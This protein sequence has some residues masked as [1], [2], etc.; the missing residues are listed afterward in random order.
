MAFRIQPPEI[1]VPEDDPFRYDLLSRKRLVETLTD[2]VG[3]FAGPCVLAVD[4]P[5]GTGKTTFFRMW[6]QHLQNENFFVAEF[7]AWETDFTADPLLAL[8]MELLDSLDAAADK[9]LRP[10]IETLRGKVPELLK[11]AAPSIISAATQGLLDFTSLLEPAE[12][13]SRYREAVDLFRGFR[14]DLRGVANSVSESRSGKPLIVLID[15]LDRC[16]PPYAVELLEVAKHLFAS[17]HVVFALALNRAEL[18]HSV[19][20]LYGDRFDAHGYLRRFFDIDYRLP[21][22]DRSAFIEATLTGVGVNDY[23]ARTKDPD[24]GREASLAKGMLAAFFSLPQLSIRTISQAI[25][26]LGLIYASLSEDQRSLLIPATTALI[27]RTLDP[28]LYLEFGSERITACEVIQRLSDEPHALALHHMKNGFVFEA[29]LLLARSP[30]T[31]PLYRKYK[32]TVE[33]EEPKDGEERTRWKHAQNVVRIV[34][35]LR[36]GWPAWDPSIYRATFERI[37]LISGLQLNRLPP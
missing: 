2:V 9:S 31:D 13:V 15:E 21:D 35:A 7:N 14:E 5:W 34:Q 22:P 37:D 28:D 16:R 10:R 17:P 36:S 25:H 32:A 24:A 12:R 23:L 26:R 18:E 33:R 27:L 20:A 4:A 1:D 11:A 30:S 19:Q 8:S 3:S 6:S 29:H